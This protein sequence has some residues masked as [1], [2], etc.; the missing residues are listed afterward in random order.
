MATLRA[1]RGDFERSQPIGYATIA[2]LAVIPTI[3]LMA[4]GIPLPDKSSP[5]VDISLAVVV[6]LAILRPI[7][8]V[9]TRHEAPTRQLVADLK[10]HWLWAATVIFLAIALPQTLVAASTIKM[11]IPD[12]NSYYADQ[13]LIRLDAVFGIDPW[14]ITHSI[15]GPAATRLIDLLYISWHFAQ[16]GFA[17]WIILGRDRKFQLRAALSFQ[18]AWLLMGGILAVAF[19]SV[20]PC[21]VDDFLGSD[22]YQPL[23]ARLPEDLFAVQAMNYL[24]ETHGHD[25]LGGGISAMPSLHVAITV[26]IGICIRDRLPKWQWLAWIYAAIIYVGSI[27]LGWHYASD[28]IVATVGMVAIWKAVGWYLERLKLLDRERAMQDE[29]AASQGLGEHAP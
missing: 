26:L 7:Q 8:L 10:S 4:S 20:G 29:V 6:V 9:V 3:W 14:R 15:F 23:M 25:S 5:F 19:A 24:L 17:T 12:L 2:A 27:H 16:I 1:M 13:A 21:F 28:G 11:H 22:Y 18:V